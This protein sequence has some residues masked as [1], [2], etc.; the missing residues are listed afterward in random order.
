MT[1]FAHTILQWSFNGGAATSTGSVYAIAS[2]S[3]NDSGQYT[4]TAQN[5]RGRSEVAVTFTVFT[6]TV[7]GSYDINVECKR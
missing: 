6:A 2:A 7:Q 5:I 1:L 4:C 3:L